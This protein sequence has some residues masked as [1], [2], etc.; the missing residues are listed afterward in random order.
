MTRKL[1][2]TGLVFFVLGILLGAFGAHGLKSMNAPSDQLMSFETGIRY[3]YYNGIGM[4][5]IAG[6]REKMD[7]SLN[8]NYRMIL[9][10]T[11]IF[12]FSIFLLVL[13]NVMDDDLFSFL[14]PITPIGG[15]LMI[16]GWFGLLVKYI[17]IRF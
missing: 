8:F 15:I 13:G 5:A 2:I 7:F 14:G 12:S 4:L 6:V 10:G 16:V 17:R 3:L 9:W 1:I 11:I